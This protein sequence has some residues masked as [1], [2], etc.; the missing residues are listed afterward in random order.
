MI[1]GLINGAEEEAK[2]IG[3]AIFYE[4]YSTW[5]GRSIYLEDLI[6]TEKMR[7][8]GLGKALFEAVIMEAKR[9]G[10]GR[11]EWQVLDWNEPAINFYRKYGAAFDE[12]WVNCSL[13]F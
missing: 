7:G 8:H 12:E 13:E 3:I 1:R 9:R 6:V 11:M 2:V 5:K 4:K 10:S